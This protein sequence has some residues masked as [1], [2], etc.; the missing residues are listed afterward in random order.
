MSQ[1]SLVC[2]NDLLRS[3]AQSL[4]MAG[5]MSGALV[6]GLLSDRFG[7]KRMVLGSSHRS[8]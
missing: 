4:Y 5:K 1:F 7:R 2:G 8:E 3:T 6:A